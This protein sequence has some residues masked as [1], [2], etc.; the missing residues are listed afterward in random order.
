MPEERRVWADFEAR[1]DHHKAR[2]EAMGIR[3]R[4]GEPP[5]PKGRVITPKM[6]CTTSLPMCKAG[7]LARISAYANDYGVRTSR[8][9]REGDWI[10]YEFE[11]GV[12]MGAVVELTTG[13]RHVTRGLFPSGMVEIS[14]DGV[15]FEPACTL[16]NGRATIT[17][18]EPLRAIRIRCTTTGNNDA[19]VYIQQPV[20]RIEN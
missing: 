17:A 18:T 15:E 7:D 13:Y 11:G 8:T 2:L 9:C 16:R 1:L 4:Q 5:K 19:Y 14:T 20:I 6:V 10:L 3:Y 12:P